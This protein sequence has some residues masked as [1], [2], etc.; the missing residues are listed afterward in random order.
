MNRL[1][2]AVLLA[3][4]AAA[5]SAQVDRGQLPPPPAPRDGSLLRVDP[6]FF[7]MAAETGGD[8]YFWD[9][10]E[11]A[12]SHVQLPVGAGDTVALA[13]GSFRGQAMDLEV[14]VGANVTRLTVFAGAQRKHFARLLQPDGR[15]AGGA[16]TTR[17]TF[18][19]MLLVTVNAPA[20]G[21]W[22]LQLGG[23]GLYSMSAGVVPS[24]TGEAPFVPRLEFVEMAGRP[25]HEG[26]FPIDG[27]PPAGAWRQCAQA[28]RGDFLQPRFRFVDE[29]GR[30]LGEL[31]LRQEEPGG[32]YQGRCR[33]PDVA[34]R[35]LSTATD[36]QGHRVQRLEAG[37]HVPARPGSRPR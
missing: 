26:W 7:R 13:Y 15:E 36:S 16:G 4:L 18:K 1:L 24:R 11:F 22:R 3:G 29:H 35:T 28:V 30:N 8:F 37:L 5:A 32:D 21:V 20:P 17:Q 19:H 10:G 12:S 14:P 23:D 33:I 25:G 34:F 6:T 9:P 2:A 27:D 31:A